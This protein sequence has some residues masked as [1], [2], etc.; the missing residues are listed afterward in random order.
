VEID[1]MTKRKNPKVGDRVEYEG[2]GIW[3][4]VEVNVNSVYLELVHNSKWTHVCSLIPH[5]PSILNLD[6]IIKS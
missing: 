3:K 4:I 1:K 5:Q 2:Q 6:W